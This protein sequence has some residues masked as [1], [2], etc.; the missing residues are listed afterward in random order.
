MARKATNLDDAETYAAGI[1]DPNVKNAIDAI[2]KACR[3]FAQDINVLYSDV[4][5]INRKLGIR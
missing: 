3:S 2:I 5:D 4:H 1:V